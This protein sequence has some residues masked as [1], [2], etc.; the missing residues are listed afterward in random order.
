MLEVK[1]DA[2]SLSSL[3]SCYYKEGTIEETIITFKDRT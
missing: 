1:N 2:S 3:G